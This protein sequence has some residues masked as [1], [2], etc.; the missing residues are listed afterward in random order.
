M[1]EQTGQQLEV[2]QHLDSQRRNT[3]RKLTLFLPSP[4]LEGNPGQQCSITE[5]SSRHTCKGQVWRASWEIHLQKTMHNCRLP[6]FSKPYIIWSRV[7]NEYKPFHYNLSHIAHTCLP[8]SLSCYSSWKEGQF[9]SHGEMTLTIS[10]LCI[11]WK[12]GSVIALLFIEITWHYWILRAT[13]SFLFS[14]SALIL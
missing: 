5:C 8:P 4:M 3:S 11:F 9:L 1:G 10:T 6:F 7:T 13:A 2:Q 14:L 12:T